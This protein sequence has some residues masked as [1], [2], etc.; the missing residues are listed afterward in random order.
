M[1]WPLEE[2]IMFQR[3]ML[4]LSFQSAALA[5]FLI[6]EGSASGNIILSYSVQA[7]NDPTNATCLLNSG[8]NATCTAGSVDA[9]SNTLTLVPGAAQTAVLFPLKLTVPAN[10]GFNGQSSDVLPL[11]NF[12]FQDTVT[13]AT[14]SFQSVAKGAYTFFLNPPGFF[15]G[16]DV[17]PDDFASTG[18][19]PANSPELLTLRIDPFSQSFAPLTVGSTVTVNVNATFTTPTPVPE[20]PAAGLLTTAVLVLGAGVGK[21]RQASFNETMAEN[22]FAAAHQSVTSQDAN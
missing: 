13:G 4:T 6:A 2:P 1:L 15:V 3:P 9:F 18:F 12:T 19:T 21:R 11:V 14:G 5:L 7:W 17:G 10:W 8:A 20:P 22:T 16:E